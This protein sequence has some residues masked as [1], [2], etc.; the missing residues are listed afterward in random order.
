MVQIAKRRE[1]TPR[2]HPQV[3]VKEDHD[4]FDQ[5]MVASDLAITK[6]NRNIV[7]ELAALGVPTISISHNLNR[8]DDFRTF[9]VPS[10]RTVF[11]DEISSEDLLG[12]IRNVLAQSRPEASTNIAT[13]TPSPPTPTPVVR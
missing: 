10:N 7:L 12:N 2:S 13:P 5:L 3:S 11:A 6:G 8:I 9:S 1:R 4:P